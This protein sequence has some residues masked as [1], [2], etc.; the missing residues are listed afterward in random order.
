MGVRDWVEILVAS[1]IPLAVLGIFLNRV[2]TRQGLS[3]RALKFLGVAMALPAIV[4]LSFENIIDGGVV[5]ALL[6]AMLGYLLSNSNDQEDA[7]PPEPKPKRAAKRRAS[8]ARRSSA[9]PAAVQQP[10]FRASAES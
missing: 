1:A 6:G 7:S 8:R 5:A 9:T 3:V 4:I 10:N 2:V